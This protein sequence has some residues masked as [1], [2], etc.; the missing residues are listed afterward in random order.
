MRKLLAF[1]LML[2][3]VVVLVGCG[4]EKDPIV[5]DTDPDDDVIVYPTSITITGNTTVTVGQNITLSA[6]VLPANT[7][8]KS[9]KWE[10]VR[11]EYASVD[12]SG[13]VTG[14]LAGNTVI[15]VISLADEKITKQIAVKVVDNGGNELPDLGGYTIKIAQA[16]HALY[17]IDPFHD[18]YKAL[19]K[20]AKKKAWEWVE[21]N[22]NVEIEVVPYPDYAEW[23]TPRWQY[24]EQ[25][26]QLGT[27][28]YDFYTVPDSQIGRFVEAG[29]LHDVTTWYA[30][31]GKGYMDSTYE[32]SGKFKGSIYSITDGE[33]GI[34]NV[35]YYNINLLAKLGMEKTPAQLFNDG[36]WTYS[37]FEEYAIAAQTK[38]NALDANT[39]YYAVAGNPVY[40]WAGMSEAGGVK[41]ADVAR[42]DMDIKNPISI[43]A[44]DTL[45]AIKTANAMSPAKEVDAGITS[46]MQNRA[47]FASGDLWFVKTSN[48]WPADLWGP[49]DA[50]KYGYVPFPRPDGIAKEDQKIGLGGTATFVMPIGRDYTGFGDECTAENIYRALVDTFLKTE[51]F[52]KEDPLYN[53]EANL[54]EH[55]KKYADSDD[56]VEAFV[57]MASRTKV[58]GFFDPLSI[59]DNPVVNTGYSDFSTAVFKYIMGDITDFAEAVDPFIP[60]LKQALTKAYT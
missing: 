31:Y 12:Q 52:Q 51:Q 47:L 49:G 6:S 7:T 2:T 22:Y 35:L 42:L 46:W 28:E 48:R 27:A 15:K 53:E 45:K 56:S 40:L 20:E 39:T 58:V 23:G 25:Q 5:D 21:D 44:V 11:P 30:Q 10:S 38:L 33:S 26:A 54:I 37:K 32:S 9:V 18:D 19:N 57:Y 24:I 41:L 13:K 34:Y 50:T 29:A 4:D 14:V 1:L 60:T 36:E 3:F 8:N 17:E 16:G 55:A 59:P 43:D